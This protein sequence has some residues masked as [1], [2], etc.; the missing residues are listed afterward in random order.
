MAVHHISNKIHGA[1]LDLINMK[2]SFKVGDFYYCEDITIVDANPVP[3][4]P[5]LKLDFSI[6]GEP[7]PMLCRVQS[8]RSLNGIEQL[9]DKVVKK[10]YLGMLAETERLA[11]TSIPCI[12][13]PA[14]V[15]GAQC[16]SKAVIAKATSVVLYMCNGEVTANMNIKT[17]YT[18]HHLTGIKVAN[19]EI[20]R[21]HLYIIPVVVDDITSRV[22]FDVTTMVTDHNCDDEFI[23]QITPGKSTE[24]RERLVDLIMNF[25][26]EH[27]ERNGR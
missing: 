5:V 4:E 18:E 16:A 20:L 11:G 14:E 1:V 6:G 27:A 13:K 12:N 22:W 26:D 17:P 3:D 15:Y 2:A 24:F 23:D 10:T 25:S 21:D 8:V 7:S 9:T 19:L